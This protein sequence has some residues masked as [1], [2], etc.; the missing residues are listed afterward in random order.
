MLIQ[1]TMQK[2]C[3]FLIFALAFVAASGCSD[4]SGGND[5][6]TPLA[7]ISEVDAEH[8]LTGAA[9][10]AV[11]LAPAWLAADLRANLVDLDPEL[12]D[13]LAAVLV[14]FDDPAGRD[15][16]AFCLAH[17]SPTHIADADFRPGLI[18]DNVESLFGIDTALTYA[19]IV[20][21]GDPAA[22]GD[23]WSTV[24]YRVSDGDGPVEEFELERDFYYWYIVF[25]VVEDEKPTYINPVN[26][27]SADPPAGRFWRDYLFFEADDGYE[28]LSSYLESQ[29]VLWKG[30]PYDKD[31]NGA[32]GAIIQ[33]VLDS[34]EFGSDAERP[35]QPVRIYAKHLGRCGEHGD[36]TTAAARAALIPNVNVSAWANDHVWNEFWERRW[37]QW[38]PVNTYVEHYY[39]YADAD[40]N[41]YRSGLGIDNDCDGVV[42]EDCELADPDADGDDDGFTRGEGDCNDGDDT[43][44]PGA[45]EI[46]GDL[47]DNDCDGI[48]DDGTDTTDADG[49]GFAI[50]DGDCNDAA[51]AVH[52]G[53]DEVTPSNNRNFAVSAWRGDGKVW[54]VSESYAGTFTLEVSVTDADGAPVDGATILVAGYSTVYP[55]DPGIMI[56]T[57]AATD[58][59]GRATFDLGEANEYYGR[60]ESAIGDLPAAAN[61]VTKLFEDWPVT[62]EVRSWSAQLETAFEPRQ[63][64]AAQEPQGPWSLSVDFAVEQGFVRAA[65]FL[66]GALFRDPDDGA[67]RMDV[68]LVDQAGYDAL[69]AGEPFEA[70]RAVEGS[71]G[72]SFEVDLPEDGGP[73]YLVAASSVGG[74]GIADG[75]LT[76][77]VSRDGEILAEDEL[78]PTLLPGDFRA[79]KIELTPP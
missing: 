35:A 21:H 17:I 1:I 12:Q 25:P 53:A 66:T 15:E 62:G 7:E 29:D 27:V 5:A 28:P 64:E 8:R 59:E 63:F 3:R 78:A 22:G 65:N 61:T 75:W 23:F 16:V 47:I 44:F 46:P 70:I 10:E 14:D 31:D 9:V 40:K 24:A 68:F 36:L 50:A 55:D 19:D 57:W 60:V 77:A 18:A 4:G 52:P 79:L 72:G 30:R 39:Y 43:V 26:G 54:T 71:G 2:T 33:W 73:Y 11:D 48:A 45:E 69:A 74:A 51:A 76:A 6:G 58:S 56:A 41:Y 20:D 49:D 42:D 37:V 32:I 13:A 34:M 67:A 38:E